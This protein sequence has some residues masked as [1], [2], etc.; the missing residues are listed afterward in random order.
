MAVDRLTTEDQRM[1]WPEEIWPQDI[2]ALAILGGGSL[3]GGGRPLPDRDRAG[4]DRSPA[5]P[6][7]PVP[8]TAV[9][10]TARAGRPAMGRCPAVDLRDDVRV[11]PLPAPVTRPRRCVRLNSCADATWTSPAR[12]GKCA[13]S[14]G[15]PPAGSVAVEPSVANPEAFVSV[16]FA[17][18]ASPGRLRVE[19][20][21]FVSVGFALRVCSLPYGV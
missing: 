5:A 15:C 17:F 6:G 9:R 3:A 12:C 2:G 8:A 16:G 19:P 14:Q 7:A 4:G 18:L 20:K 11:V 1:L 21:A 13:S 10:A